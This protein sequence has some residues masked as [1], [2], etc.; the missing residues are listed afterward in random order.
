[1]RHAEV[2]PSLLQQAAH[3]PSYFALA[4]NMGDTSDLID[5]CIP[6]RPVLPDA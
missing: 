1:L 4:R 6:C 3:S 2:D 5:F